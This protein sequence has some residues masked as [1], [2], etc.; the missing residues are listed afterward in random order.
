MGSVLMSIVLAEGPDGKIYVGGGF[1]DAGDITTADRIARWN[2]V[3]EEW[4]TVVSGITAAGTRVMCME[5]D[6]NGDFYIGG[7]FTS[8]GGVT[9]NGIFKIT[10]L[11]G[12]PTVNALGT[13]TNLYVYALALA[14]NGD[15]Y[16]GGNFTLAGGVANTA[17]IAKWDG[18]SWSPLATG[19]NAKVN[20]LA[21]APN[22]DLYVGGD[23]TDA[24]YRYICKWDGST[25]SAV[26]TVGDIDNYINSLLFLPNGVLVVG[27]EFRNAGGN[28]DGDYITF[29]SPN[30]MWHPF[31]CGAP[32][33]FVYDLAYKDN[34]LYVAGLF[35]RVG[36]MAL[37]DR[38]AVYS[39]GAWQGVGH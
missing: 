7:I 34:R 19:L 11:S 13:G 37:G 17:Y 18:T 14:P 38:V 32:S 24:S 3:S 22:G 21:F 33:S 26:G 35:S 30:G 36:D 15:L 5:F 25:F 1:S 4:E 28:A 39:N 2:P 20:A 8:A 16:V 27:G 9:V 10:D 6:A 23:F 12:T 29:Y 31:P